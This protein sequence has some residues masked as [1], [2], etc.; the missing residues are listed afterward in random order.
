[1]NNQVNKTN[2]KLNKLNKVEEVTAEENKRLADKYKV[3]RTRI[4]NMVRRKP[5]IKKICCI[6]GKENA[7]ILHNKKDPYVI[8]FL[9]RQCRTN[10]ENLVLAE[11]KRFDIREL[12]NKST[13][14]AKNF[15]IEDVKTLVDNYLVDVLSIAKYCKKTGISRHQFNQLVER[16]SHIY[17]EPT[18]RKKVLNHANKINRANL[19]KLAYERAGFHKREN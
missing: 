4:A 15:T 3:E 14:S 12:M 10:E 1:M 16:Y 17:K 19:S 5:E 11:Q 18:I 2:T 6:C 13:L 8:T 7:E 9:C